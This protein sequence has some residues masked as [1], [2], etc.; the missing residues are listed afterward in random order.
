MTLINSLDLEDN[1]IFVADICIVGAGMAGQI[2]AKITS[3]NGLKTLILESGGEKI[4]EDTESLNYFDTRHI[5]QLRKNHKNRTRQIGGSTNLWANKI[6]KMSE[7][8]FIEKEKMKLK[9]WPIMFEEINK[10]YS[11]AD[12]IFFENKIPLNDD[13]FKD[14]YLNNIFKKNKIF[15]KVCSF[16]PSKISKFNLKS[17]FTKKLLS[18]KNIILIKNATAT[19]FSMHENE[20]VSVNVR[21]KYKSFKIKSKKFILAAGAIEN[22]RF[23]LNNEIKNKIFYNHNNG[24]YFMDH[25]RTSLGKIYSG[26]KI[27]F[28]RFFM[29]NYLNYKIQNSL[30]LKKEEI[31]NNN[32]LNSHV[33]FSPSYNQDSEKLFNDF[34]KLL[35]FK[36]LNINIFIN[37]FNI[38]EQIYMNIPHEN[39]NKY[40]LYMYSKYK[41]KIN[42]PYNFSCFDLLYHGEQFPNYNSMIKLSNQKDIFHQN[43]IE[44]NW[45]LSKVDY[46]TVDF[47]KNKINEFIDLDNNFSFSQNNKINFEDSSHHS[48]TTRMGFNKNDGV[49]DKNCKFF[50]VKNLYLAGSSIFRSIG[51]ANPGLTIAA[52]SIRLGR[53]IIKEYA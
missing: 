50:D 4:N 38:I 20:I 51:Y 14:N 3:E 31:L 6:L 18:N 29:Y 46:E 35:K 37:L 44:L 32:I 15:D 41:K 5:N 43:K 11:E 28:N 33:I 23:L 16:T 47:Y 42:L 36:K 39:L 27:K 21:N 17:I 13:K 26:K 40:F 10:L 7:I 48:G 45:N 52:F 2:I 49:V 22:A 8:D 9:E 30:I 1:K 19:N 53:H 12:K 25:I 34:I 24:K